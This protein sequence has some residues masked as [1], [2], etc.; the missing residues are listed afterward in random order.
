MV[1]VLEPVLDG[2][3]HAHRAGIVH[4]DLKPENIVLTPDSAGGWTPKIIDFGIAKTLQH[5]SGKTRAATRAGAV[6]GTPEYMS[7]EQARGDVSVD[8]RTDVWAVGMIAYEMLSGRVA[9]HAATENLVLLRVMTES[10]EPLSLHAP[11]TPESVTAWVHRALSVRPDARFADAGDMLD[12]LRTAKS[13]WLAEPSPRP[14]TMMSGELASPKKT[15]SHALR[16]G[17]SVALVM[18]A[19]LSVSW[20]GWTLTQRAS[21]NERTAP[22]ANGVVSTPPAQRVELDAGVTTMRDAGSA[23]AELEDA[24]AV[25]SDTRETAD[26]VVQAPTRTQPTRVPPP[27]TSARTTRHAVTHETPY[28]LQ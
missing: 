17:R 2:L 5:A 9:F 12:A 8:A 13:E 22:R 11:H 23:R 10:V 20:L 28:E 18:G 3:A 1:A 16:S 15:S 19:M 7:P 21:R 25:R 24:S 14:R 27:A 26:R 4:R 6:M